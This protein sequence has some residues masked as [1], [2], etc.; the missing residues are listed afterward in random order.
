MSP[1]VASEV[2]NSCRTAGLAARSAS[3]EP[4]AQEAKCDEPK[5]Q[6]RVGGRR[7]NGRV[8]EIP[9]IGRFIPSEGEIPTRELKITG[10][11]I[12]GPTSEHRKEG[13]LMAILKMAT[14]SGLSRLRRASRE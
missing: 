14:R 6:K 3:G 13:P 8:G 2:R 12:A 10:A 1:K 9:E 7:G 11:V 5:S 4:R